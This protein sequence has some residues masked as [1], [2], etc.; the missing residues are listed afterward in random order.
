VRHAEAEEAPVAITLNGE[1]LSV[2]RVDDTTFAAVLPVHTGALSIQVA[3]EGLDPVDRSVT[4]HGFLSEVIGP[5]VPG[6]LAVRP[7]AT[8]H[9]LGAVAGGLVEVSLQTGLIGSTWSHD[10]HA[11]ECSNGIAP[12]PESGT[13]L[14]RPRTAEGTCM[15]YTIRHYSASGLASE[16]AQTIWQAP[17]MGVSA[18]VGPTTFIVP[19]EDEFAWHYQCEPL[20][21][22]TTC[23]DGWRSDPP[24]HHSVQGWIAGYQASRI[25]SLGVRVGLHDLATGSIVGILPA[26]APEGH[27]IMGVAFSE[28]QDTLTIAVRRGEN[29][30]VALHDAETAEEVA[31]LPVADGAPLAIALDP[32]SGRILT[33]I[34]NNFTDKVWLRVYSPALEVEFDLPMPE[35]VFRERHQFYGH[36]LLVFDALR[37]EAILV[38]T[39]YTYQG[40]S[41]PAM[42][43]MMIHRWSLP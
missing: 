1:A 26:G 36:H 22:W 27:W 3:R 43:P 42:E 35:S 10:V 7:G 2:T 6:A 40:A 34:G 30:F 8:S 29:G 37:S 38:S 24:T 4:L 13:V 21:R 19:R 33:V 18:I 11:L 41:P 5:Q 16:V 15:P 39:A 17:Q 23:A 9:V 32:G 28:S 25:V 12:G 20:P 31:N 14:L